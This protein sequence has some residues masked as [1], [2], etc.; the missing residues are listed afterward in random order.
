MSNVILGDCTEVLFS[1][2][3]ESIDL[4]ITDPPYGKKFVSAK[5]TA[6]SR[7]DGKIAKRKEPYFFQMIGDNK[8]SENFVY[9]MFRVL[10]NGSAFYCFINWQNWSI[11]TETAKKAGFLIKNMLVI[12]KSNH[13]QGD[14]KG[15][16]APK[17]EL[18]LFATKGRH[19][20]HF[21]SKRLNDVL[22]CKVLYSGSVS[23]HPAEKPISWL[24]PFV[25]AS[26]QPQDIVL[27]PYM[28]SGSTLIAAKKHLRQ[29]LGI[30]IDPIYFNVA[31]DRLSKI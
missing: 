19:I 1:I 30:E 27:D 26:S 12:N 23:H 3:S 15:A 9:E 10:K 6:N 20:L 8:F 2:P 28:G 7:D 17:H 11:L 13:G 4:V 25:L 31:V 24:E 14:I 18:V 22:D 29:Y 16:Y 5:Q 21:P